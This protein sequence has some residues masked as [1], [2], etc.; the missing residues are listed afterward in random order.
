MPDDDFND[1]F[2]DHNDDDHA[3][4]QVNDLNVDAGSE[5]DTDNEGFSDIDTGPLTTGLGQQD[6]EVIQSNVPLRSSLPDGDTNCGDPTINHNGTQLGYTVHVE[7]FTLGRA[8]APIAKREM[9]T[10]HRYQHTFY[11]VDN[12]YALFNSQLDWEVAQWGKMR[13]SSSSAFN[14]LL[15]INGVSAP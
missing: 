12:V 11:D 13:G 1:L 6:E 7:K 15:A 14:E 2:N 9:P 4:G 3:I 10:N 5:L 8:G